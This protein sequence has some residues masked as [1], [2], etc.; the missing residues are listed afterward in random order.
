MR[1]RPLLCLL[2]ALSAIA[3]TQAQDKNSESAP[4]PLKVFVLAGQSNMVGAGIVGWNEERNG[5]QGSLE[6]L[7]KNED[8]AS[9]FAH[10]VDDEGEWVTREDVWISYFDRSGGLQPGYGG[11]RNQIGPELGFGH[12][13]GEHFD[14]QV[15]L[16][17]VAWGGKS[18]AVDFRPPSA[19]GEVG[20]F[21]S[22]LI[23][24]VHTVLDSLD[25]RFADYE[26]RGHEFVGFGWHQGW[27][28]RINQGFNDAYEE[29][30]AH[31]IRDIRAEF[32]VP[33]L[34]F[35]IAET[36]MTGPDEKHPRA[37]SLMNA[38]A[39]VAEREEFRGNVAF[40]GT[41]NFWRPKE[42]SPSSQG[43]HWN[44]NAETYY[45]IGDGMGQAMLGLLRE[46]R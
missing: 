24:Q 12:V 16:V 2:A 29:N 10:L 31:F 23:E 33:E 43:Y 28:D 30:M 22:Q 35:V 45:R 7:V 6:Y 1:N 26:D 25:D 18:L 17:K 38:Q 11:N 37:L 5:G 34:P 36:G 40:V 8:T 32:E 21:Y 4:K 27:N 19:G 41:R 42:E 9:R 13:V 39:A 20:P 14:D 46:R 15:L 3:Q 44:S